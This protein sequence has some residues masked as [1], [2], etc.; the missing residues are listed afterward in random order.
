MIEKIVD[1]EGKKRKDSNQYIALKLT[2]ADVPLGEIDEAYGFIEANLKDAHT[3]YRHPEPGHIVA[4][5]F[6]YTMLLTAVGSIASIITIADVLWKAYYKFIGSRKNSP[7]DD[8][9]IFLGIPLPNGKIMTLGIGS[10]Y[11]DK[12]IFI[13]SFVDYIGKLKQNPES[14]RVAINIKSEVEHDRNWFKRK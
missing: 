6:D 3:Y 4:A 9:G 7:K 11:K 12:G 14:F 1:P 13:E 5:A 8:A 10:D 2:L